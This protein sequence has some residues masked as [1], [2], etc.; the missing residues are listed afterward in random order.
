MFRS[1]LEDHMCLRVNSV[2]KNIVSIALQSVNTSGKMTSLQLDDLLPYSNYTFVLKSKPV[3]G[4]YWSD[5]V[6]LRTKT[7]AS[8]MLMLFHSLIYIFV[9]CFCG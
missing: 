1:C 9:V 7:E 3:E 5:E 6:L 8:R 4:G 2:N